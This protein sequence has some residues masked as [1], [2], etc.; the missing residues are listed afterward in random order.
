MR[1]MIFFSI[2]L[3]SPAALWPQPLTE[4]S[5]RNQTFNNEISQ[6]LLCSEMPPSLA[7][8]LHA[9]SSAIVPFKVGFPHLSAC[10]MKY[11]T[12]VNYNPACLFLSLEVAVTQ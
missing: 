6:E 1:S 11:Y 5:T 9:L 12:T 7:W 4:M 2:Y 3:I 10:H 8:T